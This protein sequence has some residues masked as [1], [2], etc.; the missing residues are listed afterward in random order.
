MKHRTVADVMTTHVVGVH[1]NAGFKQIAELLGSHR[2]GAVPVTDYQ[3]RVIGVV[4]ETDLMRRLVPEAPRTGLR[5]LRFPT[6]RGAGLVA[7]GLM[8]TPAIT[9]GAD[10]DLAT[11]AQLLAHRGIG[12]APVV[13]ADGRLIGIVSRHDLVH[14]FVRPD[15]A[16]RQD[17]TADLLPYGLFVDR[18]RVDVQVRDGV[19]TLAGQL[20]RASLVP[21]TVALVGRVDGVIDVVNHLTY[22]YDDT[23]AHR[24]VVSRSR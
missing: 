5:R 1:P 17:I 8:T 12:R 20:E 15:A 16:I 19:V 4:S 24:R 18:T 14:V 7:C 6:R 3:S 10:T 21:I 13:D 22:E 11:A 2:I 9:V 23:D